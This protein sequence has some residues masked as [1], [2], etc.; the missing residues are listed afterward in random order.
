MSAETKKILELLAAG[1][2][3]AEDAERLLDKL[4]SA[5]SAPA[6]G[7]VC[8]DSGAK[9]TSALGGG[10]SAVAAGGGCGPRRMRYLR[11]EVERPG[12]DNVNVRVPLAFARG[13]RHWMAFL[14]AR[15]AERLNDYGID[16]FSFDKMSDEEFRRTLERMNVEVQKG[17]GKKVR[18]YAE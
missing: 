2:I 11:I 15:V 8:E 16:A 14:P 17:D 12:R 13:G 9:A 3:S 5:T 10:S 18:I 1:K 7:S 6:P 4:S